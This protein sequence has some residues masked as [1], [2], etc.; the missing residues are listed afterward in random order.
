M[1]AL[2]LAAGY[3]TRMYPLTETQPKPLLPVQGKPILDWLMEDVD[4]MAPVTR[5]VVVTNHKFIGQFTAWQQQGQRCAKPVTLLD[6]GSTDNG[7]RLGAVRDI[8]FAIQ[9]LALR[10]DLLV[11]AGD[12]LLTF[13][14]AAFAAFFLQK[15]ASC[16][17]CHEENDL[18][19]Q[20]KTGIITVDRDRR[21][22]TMEEKPQNP[23]GNL[24][25]PPFY[26]YTH[27]DAAR[28]PEAL[29][30]GCGSDAPGSLA[31]WLSARTPLY[32]WP[33]PGPRLDIGDLQSYHHAQTSYP[34]LSGALHQA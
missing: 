27:T 18:R 12:N 19:R 13:S 28:I 21:V 6:D 25:V 29:G 24:A 20:Q 9:S 22:L 14:L 31:A 16:L 5:H 4:A 1:I 32:A 15:N 2:Y 30:D 34:G 11:L 8:Q 3:A 17:M 33:M 26:C 7:Q 10:E 23:K